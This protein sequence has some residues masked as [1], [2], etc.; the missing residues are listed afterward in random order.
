VTEANGAQLVE[1]AVALQPDIIILNACSRSSTRPC[2]RCGS[3]AASRTSCSS[4][5]TEEPLVTPKILIVDD[6][7]HLRMLIQQALEELE[8][9]GVELLTAAN[10]EEALAPSGRRAQPRVPRRDDA[11]AERLRRL[12]AREGGAGRRT[13]S[14]SSC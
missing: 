5:T 7:A 10:G 9:Q 14:A 2:S 13:A 1:K 3:S 8:D 6:E 12:P 11:E 4:C